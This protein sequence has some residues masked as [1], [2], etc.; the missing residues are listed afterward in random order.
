MQF[1]AK[2]AAVLAAVAV[3]VSGA[4]VTPATEA[5]Y[6]DRLSLLVVDGALSILPTASLLK[7]VRLTDTFSCARM[8]NGTAAAQ[9]SLSP[10]IDA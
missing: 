6:Y 2:I 4:A 3:S 7:L 10:T 5:S 1:N 9:T 8:P